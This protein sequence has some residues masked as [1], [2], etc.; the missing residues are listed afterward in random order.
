MPR[1]SKNSFA[2]DGLGI[3]FTIAALTLGVHGVRP[4]PLN[5]TNNAPKLF[6]WAWERPVD[7]RFIDTSQIGVAYLAR[8][9]TLRSDDV[10]VRPRIQPL[11]IPDQTRVIAVTRIETDRDRKP[12]LSGDQRERITRTI[13]ELSALPNVAEIQ[14]DFDVTK[15]ERPFYR[16]LLVGLRRELPRGQRLS[17]TAL[18][19]WCM[20]DNWISGLP[21]DSAVPMLFRMTGDGKQIV[22]RLNSS[23]DFIEPLCRHSYGISLDEPEPRLLANRSLYIFNP[24]AWTEKSVRKLMESPK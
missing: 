3:V 21:V 1:L 11:L 12:S 2:L 18:A 9:I 20:S 13:V 16:E 15:S 22:T 5:S 8:S 7:L 19:S 6:L 4:A 24:D 23:D 10:I 17:I 14:I